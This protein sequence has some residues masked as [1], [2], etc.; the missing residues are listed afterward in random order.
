MA[1]SREFGSKVQGTFAFYCLQP[2]PRLCQFLGPRWNPSHSCGN[3]RSLGSLTPRAGPGL[4]LCL[5]STWSRCSWIPN[6]LRRGGGSSTSLL[7]TL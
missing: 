5:C 6:P 3:T 2:H 1:R 7:R 4:N